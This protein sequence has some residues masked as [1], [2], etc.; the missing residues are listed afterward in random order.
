MKIKDET[1]YKFKTYKSLIE[2]QLSRKIKIL[3]SDR[4]G[5][6]FSTE[7]SIFFMKIM[8]LYTKQVLLKLHNEMVCLKE[9]I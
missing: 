3:R 2:N 4:G 5:E 9:K 6:Y 7:F 8:V 1:F